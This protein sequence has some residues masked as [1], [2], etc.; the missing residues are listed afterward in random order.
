MEQSYCIGMSLDIGIAKWDFGEP[1]ADRI[2]TQKQYE[3]I[4]H[5]RRFPPFINREKFKWPSKY[6]V[7]RMLKLIEEE[8]GPWT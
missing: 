7:E 5:V 3:R 2:V 4:M 8:I 1:L 6:A